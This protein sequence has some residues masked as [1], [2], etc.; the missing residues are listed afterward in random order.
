MTQKVGKESKKSRTFPRKVHKRVGRTAPLGYAP[1]LRTGTFGETPSGRFDAPTQSR[2]DLFVACIYKCL[3]LWF[4]LPWI[5][6]GTGLQR[7]SRFIYFIRF[8][9]EKGRKR[10]V[11]LVLSPV[12]KEHKTFFNISSNKASLRSNEPK[13]KLPLPGV[14]GPCRAAANHK[15]ILSLQAVACRSRLAQLFWHTRR[16]CKSRVTPFLFYLIFSLG[17]TP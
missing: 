1:A 13:I 6:A 4:F 9:T 16:G 17:E 3:S 11:S 8:S 10:A 5:K 2:S 7:N 14:P 12:E 15:S